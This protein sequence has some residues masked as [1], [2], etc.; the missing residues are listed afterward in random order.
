MRI[1]KYVRLLSLVAASAVAFTACSDDPTDEGAGDAFAIVTN[2]SITTLAA[3]ASFTVTAQVVDRA[4]TPLPIEV[5]VSS[6]K[7]DVVVNDSN[8]YVAELQETRIYGRTL[9][10]D[11]SAPLILTAGALT[12]TVEV[13]VLSGAFP[14]TVATAAFSGGTVIQFTSTTNLFDANT[15]A[16]ITTSSPGY[17]ID[18]TPTRIRYLLPF[19]LPAGPVAYSITNAG[20][21]DFNLSGTFNLTAAIANND[22]F[23]P[24]NTLAAA[25]ATALAVGTPVYGSISLASDD[26]DFFKFTVTTAG[27]YIFTL[28]WNNG[29]DIDMYVRS[30]AG[31]NLTAFDAATGSKPETVTRTLQP[32]DYIVQVEAYDDAGGPR[33]TYLLTVTKK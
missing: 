18:Q 15:S 11:A 4:G 12:D 23:E 20:P 9:K 33:S 3:G 21:A 32:G 25:N 31:T 17:L 16:S 8:R 22:I 28:T 29:S 10:V 24:N 1:G 19:G 14:G 27:D 30:A 6:A 26:E 7:T 5:A 2:K 13:K